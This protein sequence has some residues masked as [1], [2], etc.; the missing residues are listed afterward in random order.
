MRDARQSFESLPARPVVVA[1][2]SSVV[3]EGIPVLCFTARLVRFRNATRSACIAV[4]V[5]EYESSD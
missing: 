2:G 1:K 3:S 5:T 4:N